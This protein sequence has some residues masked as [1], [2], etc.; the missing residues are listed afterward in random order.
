MLF[1][2]LQAFGASPF[3][4][5][6]VIIRLT[7]PWVLTG[8]TLLIYYTTKSAIGI[9]IECLVGALIIALIYRRHRVYAAQEA[10]K[11][12]V[13]PHA[14]D[15]DSDDDEDD[16]DDDDNLAVDDDDDEVEGDEVVVPDVVAGKT[17]VF[18]DASSEGASKLSSSLGRRSGIRSY[19][20]T[21]HSGGRQQLAARKLSPLVAGSLSLSL[22]LSL[23]K[24]ES[25]QLQD[26]DEGEEEDQGAQ[27]DSEVFLS[28]DGDQ[29]DMG[30]ADFN[31]SIA[32]RGMAEGHPATSAAA[33]SASTQGGLQSED[34]L[35]L[36]YRLDG[37]V[38][39][40]L[41]SSS[42]GD[43][44]FEVQLSDQDE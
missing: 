28:E 7:Q 33:L 12:A 35:S 16:D 44:P 10:A 21:D 23:S 41:V 14:S 13:Q 40:A 37:S 5:Q 24:V 30:S 25:K 39:S 20:N 22:S 3:A 31:V 36:S 8:F 26:E 2:A 6:R 29:Y 15:S 32:S 27:P 11:L 38:G 34:A 1:A 9:T 42:N 43:E 19:S 4:L 18:G 17:K